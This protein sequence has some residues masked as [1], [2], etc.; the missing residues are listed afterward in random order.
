MMSFYFGCY[1]ISAPSIPLYCSD[2][3]FDI[4]NFTSLSRMVISIPVED[5]NSFDISAMAA[6]EQP[7]TPRTEYHTPSSNYASTGHSSLRQFSVPSSSVGKDVLDTGKRTRAAEGG[8]YWDMVASFYNGPTVYKSNVFH[9]VYFMLEVQYDLPSP[10][11]E[12]MKDPE[13][14]KKIFINSRED[15]R[16]ALKLLKE[17]QSE[18]K[19]SLEVAVSELVGLKNVTVDVDDDDSDGTEGDDEKVDDGTIVSLGE[20]GED[21]EASASI[22]FEADPDAADDDPTDESDDDDDDDDDRAD[23]SQ[24]RK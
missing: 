3:N 7:L 9:E 4:Y 22:N 23:K 8:S 5:A 17:Q 6:R 12:N 14:I 13:E 2:H 19:A 1:F 18:T 11:A 24:R 21:D 16:D 15:A 10:D 20:D